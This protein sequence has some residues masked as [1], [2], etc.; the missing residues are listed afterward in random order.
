MSKQVVPAA[1]DPDL[2]GWRAGAFR[3]LANALLVLLAYEV[4]SLALGVAQVIVTGPPP[5]WRRSNWYWCWPP[6]SWSAGSSSYPA[7]CWSSSASN[8]SP[9]ALRMHVS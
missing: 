6:F 8:S 4:V 7:C 5:A 9:A 1:T 2:H 3:V